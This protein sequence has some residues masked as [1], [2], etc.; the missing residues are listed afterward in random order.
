VQALSGGTFMFV[1][2]VSMNDVS[3]ALGGGHAEGNIGSL[4]EHVHTGGGLPSDEVAKTEAAVANNAL[5]QKKSLT[6]DS[7]LIRRYVKE[8]KVRV[9]SAVYSLDTGKVNWQ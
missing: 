6:K 7:A 1:G 2:G 3:A 9:A 8:G 4:L 5:Y